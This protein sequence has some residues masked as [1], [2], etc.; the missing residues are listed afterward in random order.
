[1][2]GIKILDAPAQAI[3]ANVQ[4]RLAPSSTVLRDM[5]CTSCQSCT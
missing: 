5:V 1:M 3:P 2:V 4:M